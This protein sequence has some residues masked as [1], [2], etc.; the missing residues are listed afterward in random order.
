MQLEKN[1]KIVLSV[2]SAQSFPS[3]APKLYRSIKR[4]TGEFDK[5]ALNEK[6]SEFTTETYYSHWFT[7]KRNY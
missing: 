6:T 1:G 2:F 5:T 4:L 3:K 7:K